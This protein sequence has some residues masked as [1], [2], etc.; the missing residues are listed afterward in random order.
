[1]GKSCVVLPFRVSDYGQR[2][3][4][5][6]C[7]AELRDLVREDTFANLVQPSNQVTSPRI[8]RQVTINV[9]VC[10]EWHPAK[11]VARM[12]DLS[13]V[14]HE[15]LALAVREGFQEPEVCPLDMRRSR[16]Q[17]LLSG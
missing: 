1:M 5:R 3:V 16:L 6:W 17:Q 7:Q 12:Y 11:I 15:N 8:E 14:N 2:G 9:R 4:L 10:D 13:E